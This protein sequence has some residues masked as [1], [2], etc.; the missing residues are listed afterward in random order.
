MGKVWLGVAA[1]LLGLAIAVPDA[2]ARR[3][4]FALQRTPVGIVTVP[5][6]FTPTTVRMPAR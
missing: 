6:T 2:E 5:I 1:V 3:L 4:G